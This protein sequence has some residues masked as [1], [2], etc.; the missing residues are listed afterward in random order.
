MATSTELIKET[1]ACGYTMGW[2]RVEREKEN[3]ICLYNNFLLVLVGSERQTELQR[4][5]RYKNQVYR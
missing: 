1:Y 4:R 3:G 5:Y 2:G